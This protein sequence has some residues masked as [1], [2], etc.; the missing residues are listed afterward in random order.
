MP[1]LSLPVLGAQ[2]IVAAVVVARQVFVGDEAG[3]DDVSEAVLADP[4]LVGALLAVVVA[5]D[6]DEARVRDARP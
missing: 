1:W 4:A 3:E 5:A 2:K 6:D